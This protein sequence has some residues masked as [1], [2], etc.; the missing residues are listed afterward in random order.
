MSR[1]P[2]YENQC[3]PPQDESSVLHPRNH[4]PHDALEESLLIG[5]AGTIVGSHRSYVSLRR[6]SS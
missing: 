6:P 3:G 5:Q 1:L 2:V 4:L